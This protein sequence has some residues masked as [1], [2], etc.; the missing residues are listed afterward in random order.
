MQ[1]LMTTYLEPSL[2]VLLKKTVQAEN[3]FLTQTT[4][5]SNIFHKLEKLPVN[6]AKQHKEQFPNKYI[7]NPRS[8][9]G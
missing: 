5:S 7:T 3:Y 1:L 2:K 9:M 4:N 8:H 6:L